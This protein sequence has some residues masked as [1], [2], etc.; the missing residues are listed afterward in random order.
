MKSSS[1]WQVCRSGT[2]RPDGARRWDLAYQFLLHWA[3]E[4][5]AGSPPALSPQPQ[6]EIHGNRPLCPSLDQSPATDPDD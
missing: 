6:E 1:H 4:A 3:M 2:V 5:E